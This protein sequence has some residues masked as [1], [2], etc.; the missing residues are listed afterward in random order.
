[1]DL[2]LSHSEN[3]KELFNQGTKEV[4]T[5]LY[6]GYVKPTCTITENPFAVL[7]ADISN[8]NVLVNEILFYLKD[9]Q[10]DLI[11]I[12]KASELIN[13]K[14]STIYNL[15][16]KKEIPVIKRPGASKLMFSRSALV[17]WM[18]EKDDAV[19]YVKE[20]LLK[21]GTRGRREKML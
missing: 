18:N 16:S 3:T 7:Q 11:D 21:K 4:T 17:K 15:N 9:N 12:K 8:L 13:L 20:Q 1:M 5:T 19:D 6:R 10:Q 14:P 2:K